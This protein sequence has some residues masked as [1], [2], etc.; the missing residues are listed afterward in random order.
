MEELRESE[1]HMA[2][3]AWKNGDITMIEL[4]KLIASHTAKE[5][6]EARIDELESLDLGINIMPKVIQDRLTKLRS[7]HG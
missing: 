2:L 5:V 4:K 7:K 3:L 6:E 1:L